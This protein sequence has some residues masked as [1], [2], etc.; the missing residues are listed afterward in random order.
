MSSGSKMAARMTA[1]HT[2]TP[3]AAR[4]APLDAVRGL[5]ILWITLLHFYVDTRGVPRADA[6]PGAFFAA[7]AG[8]DPATAFAVAAR[9]LIGIPGFR[10]DVLLF[11]TGLVLSLGRPLPARALYR[12]RARAILPNYWLGSVAALALIAML[13]WLRSAWIDAPFLAQLHEGSVLAGAGYRVEWLDPLRSLSVLGRL[14]SPRAM[15]V[16]APSLWYVILLVQ[17]YLVFPPLRAIM[18]RL[19]PSWFLALAA[20]VTFSARAFAF[21]HAPFGAFDA[22]Q[23][24][25]S[26]IPFRLLAP[27]AGM[28][29][30]RW[31]ER[32]QPPARATAL[33]AA[34]PFALFAI[35]AATWLSVH[36]NRPGTWLGVLGALTPLAL[37]LPAL[38]NVA[39]LAGRVAPLQALLVWTGRHSLSLLVVQ[40]FLRFVTGTWL[41]LFGRHPEL[42]WPLMPAY[43]G[44][45][46][47]LTRWWHPLPE[48]LGDWLWRNRVIGGSADRP[49]GRS[50][51]RGR[52]P[53]ASDAAPW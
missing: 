23:T 31:A 34:F 48:A 47:L 50:T 17:F 3:R 8:F 14:E 2:T 42:T 18:D 28:V 29:A 9:A 20:V 27:A 45:A 43:L 26:F 15:Q 53:A 35:L 32:M 30:A 22:N 37:S 6:G 24:V 1:G 12:R 16:V 11:V 40:D 44:L 10:L 7:L 13:A 4:L 41:V 46:L 51:D 52:V 49:I 33:V 19:G 21:E 39:A 38:W 25:V 5:T 36:M